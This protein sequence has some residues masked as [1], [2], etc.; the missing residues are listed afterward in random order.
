MMPNMIDLLA[1]RPVILPVDLE[2]EPGAKPQA[3]AGRAARL[4]ER[5]GRFSR[6]ISALFA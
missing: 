5:L 3:G 6:T 1:G 2:A 4:L